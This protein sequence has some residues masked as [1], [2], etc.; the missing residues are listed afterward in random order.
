MAYGGIEFVRPATADRARRP[1][2]CTASGCPRDA[3]RYAA[4]A[5]VRVGVSGCGPEPSCP[6]ICW[7][8]STE[9]RKSM[10]GR[11]LYRVLVPDAPLHRRTEVDESGAPEF[12]PRANAVRQ[13]VPGLQSPSLVSSFDGSIDRILFCFPGWA[14]S[15]P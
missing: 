4:G 2:T 13:V 14:T 11:S 1:S 15:D 10:A 6:F 5:S 12:G 7:A 8:G 9:G 3:S